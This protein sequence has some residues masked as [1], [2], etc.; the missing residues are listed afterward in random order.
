MTLLLIVDLLCDRSFDELI[1]HDAAENRQ[2]LLLI[3]DAQ[4]L[5]EFC[6]NHTRP[7]TARGGSLSI[8]WLDMTLLHELAGNASD[9]RKQA[10]EA[11]KH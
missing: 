5:P 1:C 11:R 2:S 7:G 4:T 3:L 10:P 8:G 6:Q 9:T